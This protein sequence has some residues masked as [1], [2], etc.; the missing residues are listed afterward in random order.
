MASKH[1]TSVSTK[2][3]VVRKFVQLSI[4]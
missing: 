4:A 3:S 2:M 1:T